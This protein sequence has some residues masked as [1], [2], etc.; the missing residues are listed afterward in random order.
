MSS[1]FILYHNRKD[2]PKASPPAMIIHF[3]EDIYQ[4]HCAVPSPGSQR[5]K[6]TLQQMT[7][8]KM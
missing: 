6:V 7:I 5:I 1:L 4:H 2:L 3:K 8:R